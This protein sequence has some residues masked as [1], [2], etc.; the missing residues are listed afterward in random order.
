MSCPCLSST[1]PPAGRYAKKLVTKPRDWPEWSR[2]TLSHC[3]LPRALS[4]PAV[5]WLGLGD[6]RL[7]DFLSDFRFST[8]QLHYSFFWIWHCNKVRLSDANRK[9]K[10]VNLTLI[11]RTFALRKFKLDWVSDRREWKYVVDMKL[12]EL[13]MPLLQRNESQFGMTQFMFLSI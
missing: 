13:R 7:K 3:R 1:S 11:F 9:G 2:C 8:P 6:V 10:D 12:L 4:G 5:T